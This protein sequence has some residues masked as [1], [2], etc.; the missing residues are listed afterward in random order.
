MKLSVKVGDPLSTPMVKLELLT[1][2]APVSAAF[3]APEA[4]VLPAV[5]FIGTV[6]HP[7][8]VVP[9]SPSATTMETTSFVFFANAVTP[10]RCE[11]AFPQG[12]P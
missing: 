3:E 6:P 8:N 5:L 10:C 7:A 9:A 11:Y 12:M 4:C 2:A 1:D